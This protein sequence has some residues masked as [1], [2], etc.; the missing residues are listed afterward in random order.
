MSDPIDNFS[1]S[2]LV[3]AGRPAASRQPSY[4]VSS[5]GLVVAG[6]AIIALCFG[7]LAT[8]SYYANLSTAAIASGI[9]AVDSHRKSVQHLQGGIIREILTRDGRH[10][11]AGD[12]LVRL[13][14]TQLRVC[15]FLRFQPDLA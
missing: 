8:W 9:V 6:C 11:A 10:V 4:P 3:P 5:R 12:V 2:A 14:P 15:E 1:A 7:S 13:D